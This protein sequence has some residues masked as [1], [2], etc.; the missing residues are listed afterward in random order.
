[1][2]QDKPEADRAVLAASV[3]F[4]GLPPAAIEGI[5]KQG[6]VLEARPGDLVSFQNMRGG[7]GLYLLLEGAVEVFRENG[8]SDDAERSERLNVLQPGQIFGEYSLFDQRNTSASARALTASR[9][10]LLPRGEFEA[11]LER[12][13][14][15][16]RT[17]Y[18]NL[19]VYLIARL[20][21]Y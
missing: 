5:Q 11:L 15:L 14:V 18:R 17:V 4:K 3:V 13:A 9:L 19:L 6:L 12:D 10:F 20:R 7:M 8:K 1:M 21:Q 2:N 16:A